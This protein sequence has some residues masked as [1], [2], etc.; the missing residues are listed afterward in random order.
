MGF[1]DEYE[2]GGYEIRFHPNAHEQMFAAT[3]MSDNGAA[4][5]EASVR[6]MIEEAEDA[7]DVILS[8][9][10]PEQGVEMF[11]MVDPEFRVVNIHDPDYFARYLYSISEIGDEETREELA[12][13]G[14]TLKR[15]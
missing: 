13:T 8:T 2:I 7:A 10:E 6:S 15:S 3:M 11:V 9:K 5:F 1:R 4:F 12:K 14:L